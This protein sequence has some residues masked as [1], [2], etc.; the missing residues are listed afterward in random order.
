MSA[1]PERQGSWWK[2]IKAARR[3]WYKRQREVLTGRNRVLQQW[4]KR[5]AADRAGEWEK[6]PGWTVL[7]KWKNKLNKCEKHTAWVLAR[8]GREMDAM[9]PPNGKVS[10][11]MN[12]TGRW[13]LARAP[14]SLSFCVTCCRCSVLHAS[15]STSRF[16]KQT[17]EREQ[18]RIN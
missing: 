14:R 17:W 15:L 7:P 18:Q 8:R 13:T 2:F 9:K 1:R 4:K 5:V 16:T 3:S 11:K 10:S 6:A 12:I